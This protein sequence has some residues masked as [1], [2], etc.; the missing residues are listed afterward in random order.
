K[1]NPNRN[2][3]ITTLDNSHN[4]DL[5]LYRTKFFND[6][7]LTQEMYDRRALRKEFPDHEVYL[8]K[9]HKAIAKYYSGKRKDMLNDAASLYEEL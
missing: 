5:F 8:S 6:S 3:Y 2:V 4:H 1:N 9:I 7:E